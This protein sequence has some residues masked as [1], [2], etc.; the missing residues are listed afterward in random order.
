MSSSADSETFISDSDIVIKVFR[1]RVLPDVEA[2]D[3]EISAELRVTIIRLVIEVLR[4]RHGHERDYISMVFSRWYQEGGLWAESINT[5]LRDLV[6]LHQ[7][8]QMPKES[9]TILSKVN[10]A[11]WPTM[12][13]LLPVV[14]EEFSEDLR[15]PL[16]SMILPLVNDVSVSFTS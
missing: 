14:V 4:N 16:L 3:S 11:E 6:S 7:L 5:S 8:I 13:R 9:L 10:N 2:M 15:L 12:L 1:T